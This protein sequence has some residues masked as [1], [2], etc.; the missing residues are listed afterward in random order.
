MFRI[1]IRR[2]WRTAWCRARA[3][4]PSHDPAVQD[5]CASRRISVAALE[6]IGRWIYLKFQDHGLNFDPIKFIR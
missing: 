2:A 5:M 6:S 3:S 1:R 4:R